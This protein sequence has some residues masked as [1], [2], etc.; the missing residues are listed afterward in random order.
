M[1]RVLGYLSSGGK[2]PRIV[3]VDGGHAGQLVSGVRRVVERTFDALNHAR[4]L[5]QSYECL[6][7][8]PK[9]G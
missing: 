7:R 6:N 1:R 2:P 8:G 5:G 4:G 9:L 3:W